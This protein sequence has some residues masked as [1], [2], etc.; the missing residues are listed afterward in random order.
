[1]YFSENPLRKYS[2]KSSNNCCENE[3]PSLSKL[4]FSI[5]RKF[6]KAFSYWTMTTNDSHINCHPSFKHPYLLCTSDARQPA[7][8]SSS[9]TKSLRPSQSND[10]RLPG[11]LIHINEPFIIQPLRLKPLILSPSALLSN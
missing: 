2:F 1:M 10:Y 5:Y 8:S 7:T 9:P 3:N 11:S 6:Y 4:G